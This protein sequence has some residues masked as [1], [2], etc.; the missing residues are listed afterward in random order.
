M[1]LHIIMFILYQRSEFT[2]F[3]F[4]EVVVMEEEDELMRTQVVFDEN[5]DS[6]PRSTPF[7][8]RTCEEIKHM[9]NWSSVLFVVLVYRYLEAIVAVV[10]HLKQLKITGKSLNAAFGNSLILQIAQLVVSDD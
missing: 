7:Q 8:R 1:Y 10:S 2:D 3:E 9:L 6:L 5:I 4:G